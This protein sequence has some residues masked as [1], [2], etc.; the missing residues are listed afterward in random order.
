MRALSCLLLAGLA[1]SSINAQAYSIKPFFNTSHYSVNEVI[2]DKGEELNQDLQANIV[3]SMQKLAKDEKYQSVTAVFPAGSIGLKGNVSQKL[4][5]LITITNYN[6]KQVQINIRTNDVY[7]TDV[8][9]ILNKDLILSFVNNR[10][11][12]SILDEFKQLPLILTDMEIEQNTK[13]YRGQ[14]FYTFKERGYVIDAAII[15]SL[16]YDQNA[17]AQVKPGCKVTLMAMVDRLS[18]DVPLFMATHASV[19]SIKCDH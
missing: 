10:V 7:A 12:S 18:S 3:K 17:R 2:L 5:A 16:F 1:F 9:I 4:S 15:D 14:R 6:H 11:T 13:D 8:G 19:N